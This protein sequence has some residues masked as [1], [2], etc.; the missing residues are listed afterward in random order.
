MKKNIITIKVHRGVSLVECLV[1]IVIIGVGLA[2]GL[3]CLQVA[4]LTQKNSYATGVSTALAQAE[5]EEMR[6]LMVTNYM[7]N[8]EAEVT[9]TRATAT[10]LADG[11]RRY[12]QTLSNIIPRLSPQVLQALPQGTMTIIPNAKAFPSA[13]GTTTEGKMNGKLSTANV[14]ISWTGADGNSKNI[15]LITHINK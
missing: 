3:R 6:S 10:T 14:T 1:A 15:S 7:N 13:S 11:S 4:Y 2:G 12:V 9:A 5:I 8:M